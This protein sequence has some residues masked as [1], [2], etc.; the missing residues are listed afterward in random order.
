MRQA[1]CRVGEVLDECLSFIKGFKVTLKRA[2]IQNETQNHL[3]LTK[4]Y[5]TNTSRHNNSSNQ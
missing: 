5:R 1:V 4:I 2:D 3:R